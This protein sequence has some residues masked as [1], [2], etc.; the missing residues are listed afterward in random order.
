[1]F[2]IT[3]GEARTDLFG[4]NKGDAQIFDQSGAQEVIGQQQKMKFA[5]SQAEEKQKAGRESDILG[6]IGNLD[7]VAIYSGHRPEFAQGQKELRD[8]VVQNISKLKA[9]DADATM[10]FQDKYSRLRTDMELSKNF[11]EQNEAYGLQVLKDPT[12]YRD[13]SIDYLQTSG[14]NEDGTMNFVLDPSKIKKNT[15]L[16]ADFRTNVRPIIEDMAQGKSY[17]Y[18]DAEGNQTSVD[19]NNFDTSHAT[20]LL[21]DQLRTRPEV[22]EQAAY[23]YSKLPEEEQANYTDFTDYYVAKMLPMAIVDQNK[24]VVKKGGDKEYSFKDNAWSNDT[25]SWTY[26]KG[27]V[28]EGAEPAPGFTQG[29]EYEE[30]SLSNRKTETDN[31]P[32]ALTQANG[33]T[34]VGIPKGLIKKDGWDSWKVAVEHID[35]KTGRPVIVKGGKAK[36]AYV[37]VKN[38]TAKIQ[39]EY[40]FNVNDAI[41][42]VGSKKGKNNV[43]SGTIDPSKLVVGEEYIVNNETRVWNGSKLVKKK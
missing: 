31:K 30:I 11:R 19:I 36:M 9:G 14:R 4:I 22:A 3:T 34:L 18:T 32:I 42:E 28:A 27:K 29:D 6:N 20:E 23:N 24:T 16:T 37:P 12:A 39:G 33:A 25:Y 21:K 15:D 41:K 40:G 26:N 43:L 1:M 8:Y 7:K 38:N 17:S 5:R 2:N 35:P 13:E 10:E